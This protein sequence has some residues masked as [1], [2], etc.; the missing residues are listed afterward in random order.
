[1]RVLGRPVDPGQLQHRYGRVGAG[2]SA[3]E[4]VRAGRQL[5][6]K[7]RRIS[8]TWERLGKTPLPAIA[9]RRDGSFVVLAGIRREPGQEAVLLAEGRDGRP[10]SVPR[11]E[12][13]AIWSG[14]RKST[15]LNSSH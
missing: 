10:Q 2:L 11:A 6:L 7:I 5:D 4:L 8:S 12:F 14:D 15:R 3:D 13:E 1:M 9:C